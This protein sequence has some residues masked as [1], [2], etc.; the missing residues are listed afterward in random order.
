MALQLYAEAAEAD[1]HPF[2]AEALLRTAQLLGAKGRF[3]AALSWLERP[4][5]RGPLEAELL[6]LKASLELEEGRLSAARKT[7]DS[8]SGL[9]SVALDQVRRETQTE[10]SPERQPMNEPSR[11]KGVQP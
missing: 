11:S 4:R 10:S 7:L 9:S 8:A 3:Q 5:S 6:A 1:P 2:R